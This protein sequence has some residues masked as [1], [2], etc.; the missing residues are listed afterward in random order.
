M[1]LVAVEANRPAPIERTA[2]EHGRTATLAVTGPHLAAV[3]A[4][5]LLD[6]ADWRVDARQWSGSLVSEFT[7]DDLAGT[8]PLAM[9]PG[10]LGDPVLLVHS[11][12][13]YLWSPGWDDMW[14]D[15]P[16]VDGLASGSGLDLRFN[17]DPRPSRGPGILGD[18]TK[19]VLLHQGADADEDVSWALVHDYS[20]QRWSFWWSPDGTTVHEAA[21][22]GTPG[23]TLA[24]RAVTVD[25]AAGVVRLYEQPASA[26]T[27]WFDLPTS[28][29]RWTLVDTH[30]HSGP[31]ALFDS[32]ADIRHSSTTAPDEIDGVITTGGAGA[33]IGLA[34]RSGV[35]GDLVA[36]FNAADIVLG[37][38]VVVDGYPPLF[39]ELGGTTSASDA[40]FVGR[41]GETWTVHNFQTKSWPIV[42]VDRTSLLVGSNAYAESPVDDA[43]FDIGPGD[44]LTVAI[45][46]RTTRA[47]VLG[48]PVWSHKQSSSLHGEPGVDALITSTV[49]GGVVA[50][51]SDGSDTV[52]ASAPSIVSGQPHLSV[53]T[54]DGD[55][56]TLTSWTDGSAGEPVDISAVDPS[57]PG[58]PF[59]V[60]AFVDGTDDLYGSFEM[61]SMALWRRRLTAGEIRHLASEMI[62]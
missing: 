28:S 50:I 6:A 59:R 53:V 9:A 61:F 42:L 55:A 27:R 33:L 14:I 62:P 37:D 23:L 25:F 48:H 49:P 13:D 26:P 56:Q 40:T 38:W 32:S 4:P 19:N 41:A 18:E 58:V 17:G 16:A 57:T 2:R 1:A 36:G 47:E 20:T 52:Y 43:V 44:H 46:W 60:G 30:T 7:L 21:L 39:G 3:T 51:A 15:T 10:E 5:R 12:A 11:D 8:N 54:I 31:I 45:A 35:D 29:S 24:R 34:V 22:D